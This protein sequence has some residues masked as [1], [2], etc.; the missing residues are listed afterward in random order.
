MKSLIKYIIPLLCSG[1]IIAICI[2][3]TTR[4]S[5]PDR[6]ALSLPQQSCIREDIHFSFLKDVV[7]KVLPIADFLN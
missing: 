4:K 7:A 2:C 6:K 3:L 1:M 5:V